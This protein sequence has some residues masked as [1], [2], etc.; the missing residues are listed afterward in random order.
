MLYKSVKNFEKLS[1][2][3]SSITYGYKGH[4]TTIVVVFQL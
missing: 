3:Q 2:K 1:S 4:K